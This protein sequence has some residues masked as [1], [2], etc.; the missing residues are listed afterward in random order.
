MNHCWHQDLLNSSNQLA[1]PVVLNETDQ[2]YDF[3][4]TED[5]EQEDYDEPCPVLPE[6]EPQ[7]DQEDYDEP[8]PV[9]PNCASPERT[10]DTN[11]SKIPSFNIQEDYDEPQ[12]ILPKSTLRTPQNVDNPDCEPDY[13]EPALSHR[14]Y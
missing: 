14:I 6:T 13:D 5:S 4:A 10:E 9:L 12:P 7:N 8:H 2:D 11:N 1:T 3:P